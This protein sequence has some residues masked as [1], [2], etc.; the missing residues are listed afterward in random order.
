MKLELNKDAIVSKQLGLCDIDVD[1]ILNN[2]DIIYGEGGV[3]FFVDKKS[4]TVMY[5][6]YFRNEYL[7]QI[8]RNFENGEN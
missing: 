2:C 4:K 8:I 3:V 7:K 1:S 5:S 6:I